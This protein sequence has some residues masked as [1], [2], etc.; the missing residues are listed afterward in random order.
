L[1][2]Q[3]NATTKLFNKGMAYEKQIPRG[4]TNLG[5]LFPI[6]KVHKLSIKKQNMA[7]HLLLMPVIPVTQDTKIRRI[8]IQSQPR[9]IVHETLTQKSLHQ[10][11]LVEWLKV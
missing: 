3:R 9:Q 5:P 6:N 2:E 4:K 8:K 10:K 11:G 7:G 1:E